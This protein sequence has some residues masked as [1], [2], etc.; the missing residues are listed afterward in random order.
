MQNHKII[1]VTTPTTNTDAATKGYVDTAISAISTSSITKGDTNVT[2]TDTGL[3]VVTVTVDGTTA[4]TVDN[5]GVVI[6]GNFTVNGTTTTVNSNTVA[7][8]DNILTLNS[9][10][11]GTP[12]QNAGIEVNR[13]D[14]TNTQIR[15]NEGSQKW[16]FTNDGSVYN[17]IAVTTTDLTEGTNQYFT[18]AR[19]RTAL[20]AT[21]GTGISYNSSTG[22]F[23]LGSIPNS[24]LSNNSITINGSSVA[25]GGTRTLGTDDISEGSTNQYFT[26]NR[27]R[28]AVSVTAGTGISYNSSTGAFSLSSIPNS[29]LSNNS[30][31]IN[32]QSVSLGGSTTV[33]AQA[34]NALTIGTGLTGTSYNGST[35]VT[36]A[37][38]S[39]VATL[40]GTQTLTSKTL[41]SP[42]INGATIGGHMIPT[43]DNTYNLGSPTRMFHSVYVGPGSLYINNQQVLSTTNNNIVVSADINQN[44]SIQTS[45]TGN[46][47]F[48]PAGTGTLNMKG[49]MVIY[50]GNNVTSSDGNKIQFGN[51]IGVDSLTSRTTN[52][53][54]IL[55]GTGTGVVKV[56]DDL[57]V[58]GAL[59]VDGSLTVSGTIAN[60]N[61]TNLAI[62]DN[63]VDLNSDVTSGTPTE[64][65]GFRVMRGDSTAVQ[66]RWTE[67]STA[68]QFTND[69]TTFTNIVGAST[70]QTLTNKTISGSSN[71]LSNI[72]NSSLT[73]SSVTV[74]S[75]AI[76]LG[77]TATTL[78]GLTSVT[79][80]GFTGA[81]T[82]NADTATSA[83]K[84]TTARTITLGGDLSGSV[85]IDG[86]ANVTLNATVT[87]D[88][89]A[90]GT[91]TTGNYVATVTAGTGMTVTG[92]GSETAA[93]TVAI[94]STV[95]T[96]T[97]TQTL[98][99][100]TL[101]APVIGGVTTFKTGS[102]S[103]AD[104]YVVYL[105]ATATTANQVLDSI[106]ASGYTSVTYIISVETATD[107]E[108]WQETVTYNS[109]NVVFLGDQ[110]LITTAATS[111]ASFD[112]DISGGNL[113]LLVTPTNANTKFKVKA[114]AYKV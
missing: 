98:T 24:S 51:Q 39:T 12:T 71:T 105:N 95:T 41:T 21:S 82:G 40:T 64:N 5:T 9:D 27:A 79:S 1:N 46:V 111:L 60:I 89:V 76:S 77:G 106:S 30:I 52:T 54:L 67:G 2:V 44:V 33:T 49:P 91:D 65:V 8:A 93:V 43:V 69:G 92:S 23:S 110:Q 19:A 42:I 84:W 37:I 56:D 61:V 107:K 4:L 48:A 59:T 114:I 57:K 72:A 55:T 35:A 3:G 38:D 100:K 74:G 90:L 75:T 13:G 18:Q 28:S 85:S 70:T 16:T 6:S 36:V 97:G 104:E 103:I 53:D 80:T 108:V 101:T 11:T 81:L 29:S 10:W 78:A 102:T 14:S 26:T 86:S 17:P 50:A 22:A 83:G 94:D 88:A 47:E 68:W 58:T 15:W 63:L 7:V 20:S 73:N 112:A 96:L 32:G 66:L 31:T 99:N 62:A 25:L 45:G 113:R 109:S 87:G 34:A